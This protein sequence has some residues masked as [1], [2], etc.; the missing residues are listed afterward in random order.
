MLEP[1][2]KREQDVLMFINQFYLDNGYRPTLRDIAKELGMNSTSNS[3]FYIKNL[4]RKGWL[5]RDRFQSR[6][7]APRQNIN[8]IPILGVCK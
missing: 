6:T 5:T 3:T 1:P 2:T 4:T 7:V 8:G